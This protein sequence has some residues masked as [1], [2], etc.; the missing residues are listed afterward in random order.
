MRVLVT[1]GTG[2]IG[3]HTVAALAAAG[4]EPR[5]FARDPH[6][7]LG[8]LGWLGDEFQR[9]VE[10]DLPL[11]AET[12]EYASRWPGADSSASLAEL[13]FS[14]RPLEETLT[15]TLRWLHEAGHVGAARIGR[16]A[17]GR[18]GA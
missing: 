13:G 4:H 6:S 3:S 11:S 8:W 17:D 14:F 15:D 16:L 5:V 10:L 7:W 9:L 18:G 12:M 1:G 2:F